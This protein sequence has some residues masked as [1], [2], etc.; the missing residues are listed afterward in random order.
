MFNRLRHHRHWILPLLAVVLLGG[1]A[2]TM[3]RP[4]TGYWLSRRLSAAAGVEANVSVQNL[5]L[6]GMRVAVTFPAWQLSLPPAEIA[7]TIGSIRHGEIRVQI[8]LHTATTETRSLALHDYRLAA[9]VVCHD[10]AFYSIAGELEA[11]SLVARGILFQRTH[12]IVQSDPDILSLHLSAVDQSGGSIGGSIVTTRQHS[13]ANQTY[14]GQLVAAGPGGDVAADLE[15]SYTE[16]FDRWELSLKAL[17]AS[18]R[19]PFPRVRIEGTVGMQST[20]GSQSIRL[21]LDY[22]AANELSLIGPLIVKLSAARGVGR[23]SLVGQ[24]IRLDYET[25][26]DHP[27]TVG[28]IDG[29]GSFGQSSVDALVQ[30][31]GIKV[32]FDDGQTISL[33][34][35]TI[36]YNR[37]KGVTTVQIPSISHQSGRDSAA[38]CSTSLTTRFS[39]N[40][41]GVSVDG[42]IGHKAWGTLL[43]WHGAFD[44][45]F[46]NG[47]MMLTETLKLDQHNPGELVTVF[48]RLAEKLRQIGGELS[49]QLKLSKMT[50]GLDVGGLVAVRNLTFNWDGLPVVAITTDMMIDQLLPGLRTAPHQKIM[51]R[52][53][54]NQL[55]LTDLVVDY[56]VNGEVL[57][58]DQIKGRWGKGILTIPKFGVDLKKRSFDAIINISEIDLAELLRA[59]QSGRMNGR[60][61][62]SATIPIRVRDGEIEIDHGELRSVG[63]GWIQYQD[64][65][66]LQFEPKIVYL[67]QF[68]R[69]LNYGNQALAFKALDNFFYDQIVMTFSRHSGRELDAH[70][71]LSGHNPDLGNGMPFQFN[72]GLSG[73]LEEAMK[74]SLVNT[75]MESNLIEDAIPRMVCPAE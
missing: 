47:M 8:S 61:V 10:Y 7:W 18:A 37:E 12:L 75:I 46:A 35:L 33:P 54:G 24:E 43:Q 26:P 4:L 68:E 23:F 32:P 69:L 55:P 41:K 66:V 58:I 31:T 39:Q 6:G 5:G 51:V 25:K 2:I 36:S 30:A 40:Q 74:R 60:G 72:I 9:T 15:L 44:P 65:L 22:L 63:S 27:I 14:R 1:L 73:Q 70:V 20:A 16:N 28:A 49:W 45:T 57:Q 17:R 53:I 13:Q 67:D 56:A 71:S 48:P 38:F 59:F 19:A 21:V 64:D 3:L 50:R 62:F 29:S 34:R 11:A 52:S 42:S